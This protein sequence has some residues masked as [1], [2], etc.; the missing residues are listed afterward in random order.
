MSVLFC[1]KRAMFLDVTVSVSFLALLYK[2]DMSTYLKK[3]D[4]LNLYIVL[5]FVSGIIDLA[6]LIVF[7]PLWNGNKTSEDQGAQSVLR[8][9]I[10]GFS[11][12]FMVYK[13]L[14]IVSVVYLKKNLKNIGSYTH[15]AMLSLVQGQTF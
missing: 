5:F 11:L 3:D 13:M 6:W 8:I 4:I 10:L 2:F 9:V 12:I 15:H 1:V 14:V 7:F